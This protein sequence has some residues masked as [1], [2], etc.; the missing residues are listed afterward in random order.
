MSNGEDEVELDQ[1]RSVE[2]VEQD[3]DPGLPQ[4]FCVPPLTPTRVPTVPISSYRMV[5]TIICTQNRHNLTFKII[6]VSMF[7]AEL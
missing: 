1:T 3:E 6:T 7:H 4:I 5:S 2:H